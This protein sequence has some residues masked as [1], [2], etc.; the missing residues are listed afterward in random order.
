MGMT[1][2]EKEKA[3]PDKRPNIEGRIILPRIHLN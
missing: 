1:I 3:N 2:P